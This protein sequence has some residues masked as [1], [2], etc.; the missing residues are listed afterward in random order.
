MSI[1]NGGTAQNAASVKCIKLPTVRVGASSLHL[2][3]S[4]DFIPVL[5]YCAV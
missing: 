5:F 4:S 2:S 3:V 1:S